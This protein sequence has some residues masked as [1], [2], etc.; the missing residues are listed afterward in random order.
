MRRSYNLWNY[1]IKIKVIHSFVRSF[2]HSL[3][4]CPKQWMYLQGSCY[5]ISIS[6]LS[7]NAAK[8]ACK[9]LGSNLAMVTSQAEQRALTPKI[10]RSVWIGLHRNPRDKSRWLLLDGTQATY[11]NWGTGEPNNY[12]GNPEDCGEIW[13]SG[14][15]NDARCSHSL[16][17]VCETSGG[18]EKCSPNK[19]KLIFRDAKKDKSGGW[20]WLG[21]LK[22][23][24]RLQDNYF[25][26]ALSPITC[27][28]LK[29]Q[30]KKH[31]W[32]DGMIKRNIQLC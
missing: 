20:G 26:E 29:S 15:W 7:W 27:V 18:W 21:L 10:S 13:P 30:K 31:F 17:Y 2:V 6:G 14:K 3:G 16:R 23:Y 1:P 25:K 9:V 32:I 22:S 19:I 4:A 24:H 8:A 5:K 12:N 11:F 28:T